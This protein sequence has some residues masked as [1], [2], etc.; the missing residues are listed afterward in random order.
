MLIQQIYA[1]NLVDPQCAVTDIGCLDDAAY[2]LAP[3]DPG[4]KIPMCGICFDRIL[5]L[6]AA[7][8][9][10]PPTNWRN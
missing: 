9:L 6:M 4:N 8:G 5:D 3:D 10:K 2:W 7:E 1:T